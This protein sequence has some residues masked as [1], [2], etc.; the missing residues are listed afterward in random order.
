MHGGMNAFGGGAAITDAFGGG[1]GTGMST[2]QQQVLD[3][4]MS[5]PEEQGIS[6]QELRSKLRGMN[7][8][9]VR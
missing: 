4:I 9:Q 3:A 1:Q 2:H 5:C 8:T 6:V 7:E